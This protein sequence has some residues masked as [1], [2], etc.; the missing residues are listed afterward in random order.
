MMS[1][2][3]TSSRAPQHPLAGFWSTSGELQAVFWGPRGTP[4]TGGPP[5]FRRSGRL[6]LWSGATLPG[7]PPA[8]PW[9]PSESPSGS[10]WVLVSP[11]LALKK[12]VRRRR[13]N[14][15]LPSSPS[16]DVPCAVPSVA[17]DAWAAKILPPRFDHAQFTVTTMPTWILTPRV[18][19]GESPEGWLAALD[20]QTRKS[21]YVVRIP[22]RRGKVPGQG[23]RNILGHVLT[24]HA[25]ASGWSVELVPLPSLPSPDV[26]AR[27]AAWEYRVD[28]GPVGG[29]PASW[30]VQILPSRGLLAAWVG[31]EVDP[32][33]ATALLRWLRLP[34]G[35]PGVPATVPPLPGGDPWVTLLKLLSAADAR[36]LV[37]NVF[38]AFETV[39]VAELFFFVGSDGKARPRRDLPLAW[40]STVF[41]RRGWT[42]IERA[43][44]LLPPGD[45]EPRRLE[46]LDVIDEKLVAGSL[47]WSDEAQT[48]WQA[49][50]R[51]V[52]RR[53][54]QAELV[55]LSGEF[56]WEALYRQPARVLEAVWR[57]LDVTDA[58]LCL[59]KAPDARWRRFVT[60]RREKELQEERE[61]C[62]IWRAR[63]ELTLERELDAWQTFLEVLAETVKMMADK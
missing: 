11:P 46:L 7:A 3:A 20:P 18:A 49:V 48:L 52:R 27:V 16:G 38:P 54:Q 29:E 24:S 40:L 41:P 17:T 35:S 51:A 30:D 60:A 33:E 26:L 61:F 47:L 31:R 23:W 36:L 2:S 21:L 50:F 39:A 14:A 10:G 6:V 34:S 1:N 15:P 8:M 43:A 58:A 13:K 5:G 25:A 37:Q 12:P 45:P 19:A 9:G 44:R 63:G 22:P 62:R 59:E 42:E 57:T 28:A 4:V 53:E 32:W 56:S 55:R